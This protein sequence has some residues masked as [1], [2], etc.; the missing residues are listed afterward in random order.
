MAVRT[1][2]VP[3]SATQVAWHGT[4]TLSSWPRRSLSSV[5]HKAA[6]REVLQRTHC[7]NAL[8][9]TDAPAPPALGELCV[10]AMSAATTDERMNCRIAPRCLA[11]V[12]RCGGETSR[13]RRLKPSR[14]TSGL[15]TSEES[16]AASRRGIFIA[17]IG[18][19]LRR[20][21]GLMHG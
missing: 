5:D 12:V 18:R 17:M 16:I 2:D 21:R 1:T 3:E 14:S 9:P 19:L 11:D 20:S 13:R 7:R 4:Y 15:I 10:G 6:R 8:L